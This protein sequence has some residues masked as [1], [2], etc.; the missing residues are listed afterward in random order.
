MNWVPG[1]AR[2]RPDRL[3]MPPAIE[4]SHRAIC[5]LPPR[6]PPG[7]AGRT[8]T[9]SLAAASA[10]QVFS[11]AHIAATAAVT[12]LLALAGAWWR[13]P[14]RA[15]KDVAAIAVLSAASVYLW[16]ASPAQCGCTS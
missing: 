9:Y 2:N 11:H 14:H 4:A 5:L 8:M 7:D 1:L 16:R 15:W 13:L 3:A 10:G 12:A 6:L